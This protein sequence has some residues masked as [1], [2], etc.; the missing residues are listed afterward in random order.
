VVSGP[1]YKFNDPVAMA[2][3]GSD[4]FV[5]NLGNSETGAGSSVTELHASTGALVR[6]VSG[7]AYTSTDRAQ[8]RWPTATCS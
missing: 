2:V 7:P 4:M 3:A 8:W 5:A 6:V 1:A